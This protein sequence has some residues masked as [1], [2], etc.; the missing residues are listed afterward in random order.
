MYEEVAHYAEWG[1]KRRDRAQAVENS[2]E[3]CIRFG[4][5]GVAGKK[6]TARGFKGEKCVGGRGRKK[7]RTTRPALDS[8]MRAARSSSVTR[9]DTL[10]KLSTSTARL[11]RRTPACQLEG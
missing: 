8:R 9:V 4:R 1:L 10:M 7:Q 6:R 5:E 11:P 2:E 3:R